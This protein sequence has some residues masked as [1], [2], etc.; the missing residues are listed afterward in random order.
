MYRLWSE[1]DIGEDG[2]IFA[3]Q[4]AGMRWLQGNPHVAEIA[5]EDKATVADCI[6]SCFDEGFFSWQKLEIIK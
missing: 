3:T 5:E 4:E 2:L 1:W 6:A